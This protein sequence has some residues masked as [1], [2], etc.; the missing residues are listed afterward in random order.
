[1]IPVDLYISNFKRVL[2]IVV[3]I[4]LF[5]T[6]GIILRYL[7]VDDVNSYT[8]VTY[9]EMYNQD[10]NIDV[11]FLGSSHAFRSFVPEIVDDEL[12]VNSFNAGSSSQALDGSYTLLI[13][14][15]KKN[16]I[17]QVYLEMFYPIPT[18]SVEERKNNA[19]ETY[20]ISDYLK[21]SLNKY[22]YIVSATEPEYWINGFLVA[23]REWKEIFNPEYVSDILEKKSQDS[24]K[25]YE[26][27]N[28]G[29]EY[30]AGK[31]YVAN[32]SSVKNGTYVSKGFGQLKDELFCDDAL[33]SLHS[34]CDYCK[35]NN[36]ELVLV[37]TPIP[38][39]RLINAGD[40]DRYIDKVTEICNKEKVKY[41]DFNLLK[42]EYFSGEDELFEQTDHLNNFG[43]EKFTRFFCDFLKEENKDIYF[44]KSYKEKIL[45]RNNIIYG[46]LLSKTENDEGYSAQICTSNKC[47][48]EFKVRSIDENGEENILQDYSKNN[49]LYLPIQSGKCIVE[50][51]EENRPDQIYINEYLF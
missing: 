45:R 12:N 35:K 22:R 46:L 3:T 9:H 2:K 38:D 8:R 37:T 50:Y 49:L 26:Y 25:S 23:R 28:N 19:T 10:K 44:Y 36:I 43:A 13:E 29:Y 15:Q 24:Y 18:K 17:K 40:Y 41:Y 11:L 21:P 16:N 34:I 20:I 1:M 14:A 27:V 42:E 33:K 47:N 7:L 4:I 32:I 39:F 51:R 48:Y 5:I 6:T 31:G 30:Y